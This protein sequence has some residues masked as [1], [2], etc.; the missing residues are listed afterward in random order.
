MPITPRALVNPHSFDFQINNFKACLEVPSNLGITGI[1]SL[2]SNL[3]TGFLTRDEFEQSFHEAKRDA[4]NLV[5]QLTW[6]TEQHETDLSI[7]KKYLDFKLKFLHIAL[8]EA[9]RLPCLVVKRQDKLT[10]H[11]GSNR[12][13][14]TG[15]SKIGLE[16]ELLVL[17][18]DFDRE[19]PN[20]KIVKQ[21]DIT[22]DS[23]LAELFGVPFY[24]YNQKDAATESTNCQIYLQWDGLPGPCLHYVDPAGRDFFD[25]QDHTETVYA[26]NTVEALSKIGRGK[27]IKVWADSPDQVYDSSLVFDLEYQGPSPVFEKPAEISTLVYHNCMFD[28]EETRDDCRIYLTQ[29]VTLDLAE[30]LLWL[31]LEHN[32]YIDRHFRFAFMLDSRKNS[33]KTIS[34]SCMPNF[35]LR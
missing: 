8:E 28:P 14:A 1:L 34:A 6:P 32:I 24:R 29:G 21:T 4:V 7:K 3:Y 11:T 13:L 19:Y 25:W 23:Q 10:W 18:T 15:I 27:K 22:Q 9:W 16:Q 30:L 26:N 12:I 20:N 35:L 31:D 5:L 17:C 33:Q 2:A